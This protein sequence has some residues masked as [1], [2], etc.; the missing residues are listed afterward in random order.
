MS[1]SLFSKST[2]THSCTFLFYF[3]SPSLCAKVLVCQDLVTSDTCYTKSPRHTRSRSVAF[4]SQNMLS[5]IRIESKNPHSSTSF[6]VVASFL[7]VLLAFIF[8]LNGLYTPPP[9][10]HQRMSGKPASYYCKPGKT[11]TTFLCEQDIIN[12]FSS[13]HYFFRI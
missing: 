13:R 7:A 6:H 3:S 4:A 8:Y 2:L 1:K 11:F 5:S 10:K 12:L 9:K